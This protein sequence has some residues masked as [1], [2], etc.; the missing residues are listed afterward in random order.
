MKG[1]LINT[2]PASDDQN[3]D[4]VG[5]PWD[6][7]LPAEK[8]KS[9]KNE[10]IGTLEPDANETQPDEKPVPFNIPENVGEEKVGKKIPAKDVLEPDLKSNDPTE[11]VS[12]E[13]EIQPQ[14]VVGKNDKE[15]KKVFDSDSIG[16]TTPDVNQLAESSID[17]KE[18]EKSADEEI[19]ALIEDK[20][21]AMPI[22]E[23]KEA[24]ISKIDKPILPPPVSPPPAPKPEESK[25][26]PPPLPPPVKPVEKKVE[27]VVAP[28]PVPPAPKPSQTIEPEPIIKRPDKLDDIRPQEDSPYATIDLKPATPIPD[29]DINLEDKPLENEH[30]FPT[31]SSQAASLEDEAATQE[32]PTSQPRIAKKQKE[33]PKEKKQEQKGARKPIFGF[34]KKPAFVITG[35]IILLL[36]LG[37]YMTELGVLSVGLEKVYGLFGVE[38]LWGGLSKNPEKALALSAVK[39]SENLNFKLK[40]TVS[41]T[42]NKTIES[43]ITSPLVALLNTKTFVNDESLISP[44][45]VE[46]TASEYDDYYDYYKS[47]TDSSPTT[48]TSDDSTSTETAVD[49]TSDQ[50]DQEGFKTEKSTIKE[51]SLDLLGQSSDDAVLLDLVLNKLVGADEQIN[52]INS[53]EN[54]YLK[55]SENIKF[56]ASALAD[57]WLNY[58]FSTIKND[59]IFDD[60]L[61]IDTDSGFSITGRRVANEKVDKTR[62]YKYE[63]DSLEIGDSFKEIGIEKEIIQKI[64]GDVWISIKDKT[65]RK[66]D[67]S[68]IPS[69]SSSIS[70]ADIVFELY[71]F[72]VEN[73]ILIPTS[74]EII[75][76]SAARVATPDTSLEPE[77]TLS[78]DDQ[79]KDDLK[80]IKAALNVYKESHGGY[81]KSSSLDKLNESSSPT[82][83]ALLAYLTE[84][85]ADSKASEGWYYAY[86]SDGST[87]RLSARLEDVTD[88]DATSVGGVSLYYLVN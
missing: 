49:E 22:D 72:G 14:N 27:P 5:S 34:F 41:L 65:I 2:H 26:V 67:I 53:G 9:A 30:E 75:D 43:P 29:I 78:N 69:I 48:S 87:F 83:A 70:R 44:I 1:S 19:G 84:I 18:V 45:K 7:K 82:R 56:D 13:K 55:S 16:V 23:T 28:D 39:T 40:G 81:P 77:V 54:L 24:E 64:S 36:A 52:L 37:T 57:K 35:S 8:E 76:V 80:K 58:T 15:P 73:S 32:E 20:K 51:L 74:S 50:S 79:R 31:V 33:Q 71:D 63:I 66:V 61:S 85:P 47:N 42:V 17:S 60:F 11:V 10:V 38:Q 12:N 21:S 3:D 88:A 68:I 86:V 59:N 6:D 46:L 62:C 25:I 4:F